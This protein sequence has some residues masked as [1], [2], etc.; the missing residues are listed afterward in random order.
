MNN[1]AIQHAT[2]SVICLLN[3]D[4]EVITPDW[5]EK[6][7]MRLELERVGAVGPMLY[8][9]DDT[10]QHAG[11]YSRISEGSPVTPLVT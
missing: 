4:I 6:L 9:P 7:V 8:Y 10:I 1:W 3:D 11:V 2:G 5:L